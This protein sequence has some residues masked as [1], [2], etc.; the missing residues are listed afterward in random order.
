[1]NTKVWRTYG[2]VIILVLIGV[3]VWYVFLGRK[4]SV[5]TTFEQCAAAGYPIMEKYPAVCR[6]SDGRT[7][8]QQIQSSSLPVTENDLIRVQTPRTGQ[9]VHTPLLITGEARGTWFFEASFPVRLKD[10]SGVFVASAVATAKSDWMTEEFVPFKATLTI[11]PSVH[12]SATLVF[13]KDNPSG[14]P[15]NDSSVSIPVIVE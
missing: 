11:P 1:M 15:Q 10:S 7:F 9:S 4:V 12:G 8:T 2:L 5:I 14:L 3:S 13:E 6:T